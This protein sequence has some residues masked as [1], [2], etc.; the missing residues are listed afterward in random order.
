MTLHITDAE[1]TSDQ[2]G[3]TAY[4]RNGRW[5]ITGPT[6][7]DL[8][9]LTRPGRSF[10]RN[11]AISAM[12]IAEEEARPAPDQLLIESLRSELQ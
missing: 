12:T 7:E 5:Y 1:I 10:D 8:K 6:F 9:D 2:V 4:Q 11:Q 3:Q